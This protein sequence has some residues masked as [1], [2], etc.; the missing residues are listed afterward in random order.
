[1]SYSNFPQSKLVEWMVEFSLLPTSF[2]F[3]IYVTEIVLIFTLRTNEKQVQLPAMNWSLNFVVFWICAFTWICICVKYVYLVHFLFTLPE[4]GSFT[5]L[6]WLCSQ[7]TFMKTTLI[8]IST[9][10]RKVC[11]LYKIA[12]LKVRCQWKQRRLSAVKV[13]IFCKVNKKYSKYTYG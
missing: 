3:Q 6:K 12:P 11:V 2:L 9:S 4:T 5:M 1:M 8:S 7:Q 10:H 13:N